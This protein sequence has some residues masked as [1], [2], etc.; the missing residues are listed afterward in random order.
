MGRDA[1][2]S[3]RAPGNSAHESSVM[4]DPNVNMWSKDKRQGSTKRPR[5]MVISKGDTNDTFKVTVS[6]NMVGNRRRVFKNK[7]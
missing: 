6:T 5:F 7:D 1:K 2:R 3:G 4:I